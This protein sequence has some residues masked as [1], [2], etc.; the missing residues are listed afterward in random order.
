MELRKAVVNAVAVGIG[1]RKDTPGATIVALVRAALGHL[2]VTPDQVCLYSVAR[3]AREPGMHEAAA[4]LGFDLVFLP[5]LALAAV[6][7]RVVTQS[8]RVQ[9]MLGIGSVAEAAALAGG[10]PHSA[11]VVA[12]LAADGATCAIAADFSVTED[13][14]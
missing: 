11:I 13:A 7:A 5:D 9:A 14:Q 2:T 1:C 12:R 8:A 6:A 3:K 4:A 10:G